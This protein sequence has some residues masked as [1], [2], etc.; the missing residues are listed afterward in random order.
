M[1]K[2][3]RILRNFEK[4]LSEIGKENV[5]LSRSDENFFNDFYYSGRSE[6]VYDYNDSCDLILKMH[7]NLLLIKELRNKKFCI[8]K[9]IES[10][11]EYLLSIEIADYLIKRERNVDNEDNAIILYIDFKR[12]AGLEDLEVEQRNFLRSTL[13]KVKQKWENYSGRLDDEKDSICLRE[14]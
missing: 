2:H 7:N 14:E 12:W 5:Y 13:R 9:L 1:K 10:K 3:N 11:D 8:K 6:T 4:Y